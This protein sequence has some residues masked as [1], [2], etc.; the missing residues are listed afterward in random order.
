MAKDK[1]DL[2]QKLAQSLAERVLHQKKL[3]ELIAE[4]ESLIVKVEST[5][6]KDLLLEQ[7]T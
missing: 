2:K 6:S 4:K 1:D 7:Q 3:D 5:P